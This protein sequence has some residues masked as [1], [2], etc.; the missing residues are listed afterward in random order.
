MQLISLH[1]QNS[2]KDNYS[3]TKTPLLFQGV[4]LLMGLI[5]NIDTMHTLI[6]E[7]LHTLNLKVRTLRVNLHTPI[8]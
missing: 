5:A 7:F 2:K 6:N 3:K 4:D 1:V 8:V